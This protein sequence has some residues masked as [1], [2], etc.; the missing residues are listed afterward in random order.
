VVAGNNDAVAEYNCVVFKSS[1]LSQVSPDF[2]L[3]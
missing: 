2:F 1:K 3:I